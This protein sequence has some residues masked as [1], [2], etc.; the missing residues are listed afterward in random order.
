MPLVLAHSDAERTILGQ[1]AEFSMQLFQA[2][3]GVGLVELGC[4]ARPVG[5]DKPARI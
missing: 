3:F 5:Q 1:P 2:Y 4:G